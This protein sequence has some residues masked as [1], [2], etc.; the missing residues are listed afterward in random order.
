MRFLQQARDR[1]KMDQGRQARG[2]L[3]AIVVSPV[4]AHAEGRLMYNGADPDGPN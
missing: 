1:R 2:A 3:A 4:P